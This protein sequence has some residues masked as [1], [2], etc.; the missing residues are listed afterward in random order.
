M[1]KLFLIPLFAMLLG[2]C[3]SFEEKVSI[4]STP[5]GAD[6]YIN[7]IL[8]GQT[9][10]KVAL[11]KDGNYEITITKVGYKPQTQTLTAKAWNPTVKFGILV[12]MGYYKELYPAPLSAGLKPNFLPDSVGTQP[13]DEMTYAILQADLLRK[14]GA[15]TAN[16]YSYMIK[17]IVEFYSAK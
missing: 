17:T 4:T 2:A 12:D 11:E 9:P 3:T 15:I 5:E 1:K 10:L 13:F 6:V 16:E 8:S 14:S 7:G